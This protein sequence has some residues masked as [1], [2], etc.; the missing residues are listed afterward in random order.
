M[1]CG[2]DSKLLNNLCAYQGQCRAFSYEDWLSR[3][4]ESA[5]ELQEIKRLRM[6]LHRGLITRDWGLLGLSM[7]SSEARE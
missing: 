4:T 5:E 3:Y 2:S 6:L 1:D 7:L